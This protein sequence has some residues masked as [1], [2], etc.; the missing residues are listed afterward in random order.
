MFFCLLLISCK[1]E[2]PPIPDPIAPTECWDK[3]IGDYIVYDTTSGTSWI[4]TINHIIDTNFAGYLSD[5]LVINNFNNE[6]DLN[7][8]FSC[9]SPNIP[10]LE[11][12]CLSYDMHPCINYSNN[13]YNIHD[14][15]DDTLTSY[16][17]NRLLNDTII[18][19]FRK[20]NTLY[21]MSDGV[22]YEDNYYKHIAVKQN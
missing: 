14:Y 2:K 22:I 20:E 7:Y 5:F 6:F 13:R 15:Y 4:M 17:E 19:Y 21:W 8:Q 1:R 12:T 3:F 16:I 10:W 18:L 9:C 11:Y